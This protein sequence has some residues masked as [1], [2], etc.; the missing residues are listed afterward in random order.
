MEM[1]V[2]DLHADIFYMQIVA[3]NT[4]P[5][6]LAIRDAGILRKVFQTAHNVEEAEKF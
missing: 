6:S 2:Y 4:L 3:V 5:M 1:N